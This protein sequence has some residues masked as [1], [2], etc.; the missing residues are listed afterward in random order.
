LR[1][2]GI[3]TDFD[4]PHTTRKLHSIHI[5]KCLQTHRKQPFVLLDYT[6]ELNVRTITPFPLRSSASMSARFLFWF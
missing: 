4:W 5:F 1:I 3:K 2:K 6:Y